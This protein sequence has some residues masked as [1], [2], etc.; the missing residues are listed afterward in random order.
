M[1]KTVGE[2]MVERLRDWGVRRVFGYP[3]DAINGILNALRKQE[4][5]PD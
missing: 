5:Q 1:G 4:D 3:G 2:F